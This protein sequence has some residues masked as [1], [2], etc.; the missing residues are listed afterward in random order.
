MKLNNF[1]TDFA[2]LFEDTDTSVFEANTKFKEL[3]EW[4]SLQALLVIGLADEK[5]DA[6]ITGDSIND[7]NTI[8]ELYHLITSAK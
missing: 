8:E 1:I 3:E 7:V 5:F 6:R 2:E 4:S